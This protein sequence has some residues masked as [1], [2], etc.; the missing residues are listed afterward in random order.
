MWMICEIYPKEMS[1][2]MPENRVGHKSN[3]PLIYARDTGAILSPNI[4][5]DTNQKKN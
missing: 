5:L 4:F 3:D 1:L 2:M